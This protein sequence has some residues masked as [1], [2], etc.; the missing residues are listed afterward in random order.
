MLN[1]KERSLDGEVLAYQ[2][3]L[4]AEARRGKITDAQRRAVINGRKALDVLLKELEGAVR[5]LAS[6]HGQYGRYDDM[7]QV[8]RLSLLTAAKNYKFGTKVIFR[9]YAMSHMKW[10]MIRQRGNMQ[11]IRVPPHVTKWE[12]H[13]TKSLDYE[14]GDDGFTLKNLVGSDDHTRMESVCHEWQLSKLMVLIPKKLQYVLNLRFGLDGGP[15]E[16]L[17]QVSQRLRVSRERVRQM[18][19]RAIKMIRRELKLEGKTSTVET[20]MQ[21]PVARRH[22]V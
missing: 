19:N 17:Q 11:V 2:K 13:N 15:P 4:R 18:E 3:G 7:C 1:R 21:K 10:H 8:C 6:I 14:I 16:T 12:D 5:K 20:A 22:A 9:N